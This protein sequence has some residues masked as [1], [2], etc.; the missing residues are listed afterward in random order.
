MANLNPV[1]D[2]VLAHCDDCASC[3]IFVDRLCP[4]GLEIL[5]DNYEPEEFVPEDG[6]DECPDSLDCTCDDFDPYE[7]F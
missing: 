6:L 4:V 7:G 2:A 5:A 3:D 1:P